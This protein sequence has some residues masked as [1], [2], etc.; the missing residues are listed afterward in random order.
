MSYFKTFPLS[1]LIFAVAFSLI[2]AVGF[3]LL[4][5]FAPC[6]LHYLADWSFCPGC[7]LALNSYCP[8]CFEVSYG[9]FCVDCGHPLFIP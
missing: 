3:G 8:V 5:A 9:D 2:L 1:V 4:S 7:G 6:T